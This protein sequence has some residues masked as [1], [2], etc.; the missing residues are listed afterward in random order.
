MRQKKKQ[1]KN[2]QPPIVYILQERNCGWYDEVQIFASLEEVF[3]RLKGR[4]HLSCSIKTEWLESI[5]KEKIVK[6]RTA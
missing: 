6:A 3:E 2:I 5:K 1:Q 4:T